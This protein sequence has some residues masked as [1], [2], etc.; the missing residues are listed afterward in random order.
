MKT[1]K[2]IFIAV[3]FCTS[4]LAQAQGETYLCRFNTSQSVKQTIPNQDVMSTNSIM[5]ITV[6]VKIKEKNKDE[7]SV[8]CSYKEVIIHTYDK[9]TNFKFDSKSTIVGSSELDK[10]TSQFFKSLIG[11]PVSVI[12]ASD[13]SVKSIS[14]F[15][16]VLKD[17]QKNMTP[18]YQASPQTKAYLQQFNENAL[19]GQLESLF[20][21]GGLIAG[22]EILTNTTSKTTI[23]LQQ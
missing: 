2:L 16:A 12:L 23:T 7:I 18:A 8:D 19:K 17:L 11:K 9:Q 10:L 20:K 4:M 5:G 14:G 3:C 21:G 13:G 1:K 15:E 22:T 6:E